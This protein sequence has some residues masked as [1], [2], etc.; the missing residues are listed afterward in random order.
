MPIK[1]VLLYV[2]DV[3]ILRHLNI[4]GNYE[5]ILNYFDNF[6][7]LNFN[8]LVISSILWNKKII[9]VFSYFMQML[10]IKQGAYAK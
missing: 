3:T 2:E 10:V 1:I 7:W 6:T 4:S 5:I 8:L 9:N